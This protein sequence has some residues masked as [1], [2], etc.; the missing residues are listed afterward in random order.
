MGSRDVDDVDGAEAGWTGFGA[1]VC[2]GACSEG[3]AGR[4]L[5]RSCASTAK[6]TAAPATATSRARV[7]RWIFM[8]CLSPLASQIA[9][10]MQRLGQI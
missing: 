7:L 3:N 6:E 10:G 5:L 9:N 8:E 2:A 4:R 1:R